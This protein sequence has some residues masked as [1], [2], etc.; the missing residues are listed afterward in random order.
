VTSSPICNAHYL[1]IFFNWIQTP[2]SGSDYC[3]LPLGNAPLLYRDST[4]QVPTRKSLILLVRFGCFLPAV[5]VES[6]STIKVFYGVGLS[7]QR[8]TPN[9]E[10]QG[11][12]FCLDLHLWPVRHLRLYQ[13]LRY[14]R[15]SS[16][17]HVTTQAPALPQSKHTCYNIILV[18]HLHLNL[19]TIHLTILYFIV[20]D[21]APHFSDIPSLLLVPLF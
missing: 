11:I 12:P 16:Q 14:L 1:Q 6:F 18:S 20:S 15:H 3:R 21:E 17:D 5:I 4:F 10:D 13:Q 8:S 19:Q 2:N 9:L 7:T